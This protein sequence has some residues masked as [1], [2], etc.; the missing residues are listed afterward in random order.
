M[1]PVIKLQNLPWSANAADIRNYFDSIT[2]PHGGVQIIGGDE[3]N[4]FVVFKSEN[5]M[6]K[7]MTI[8]NGK[9]HSCPIQLFISNK[10]EMAAIIKKVR[11]VQPAFTKK[12][13]QAENTAQKQLSQKR[14]GDL[15]YS[16]GVGLSP[17]KSRTESVNSLQASPHINKY[18]GEDKPSLTGSHDILTHKSEHKD[19]EETKATLDR[20]PHH[21][22]RP[23]LNVAHN[24]REPRLQHTAMKYNIGNSDGAPKTRPYERK[25]AYNYMENQSSKTCSTNDE[26]TYNEPM[27]PATTGKSMPRHRDIKPGTADEKHFDKSLKN[28]HLYDNG[29]KLNVKQETN[30][31]QDTCLYSKKQDYDDTSRSRMHIKKDSIVGTNQRYSRYQS[32]QDTR[33]INR[34]QAFD[35]KPSSGDCK[36]NYNEIADRKNPNSRYDDW[37]DRDKMKERNWLPKREHDIDQC[38]SNTD[39]DQRPEFT[40]LTDRSDRDTK[41]KPRDI[42]KHAVRAKNEEKYRAHGK[43]EKY[44]GVHETRQ[45]D[46][47]DN[48]TCLKAERFDDSR[49]ITYTVRADRFNNNHK[50]EGISGRNKQQD[51]HQMHRTHQVSEKSCDTKFEKSSQHSLKPANS[52]SDKNRGFWTFVTNMPKYVT[53]KDVR[54]F[55]KGYLIPKDGL[56]LINSNLGKR[57]GDAFVRFRTEHMCEMALG[58]DGKTI[59]GYTVKVERCSEE[60]FEGA[61]D[62]FLPPRLTTQSTTNISSSPFTSEYAVVRNMPFSTTDDELKDFFTPIQIT[63]FI[64][65]MDVSGKRTGISYIQFA[66]E[67]DCSKACDKNRD[68]LGG[69]LIVIYPISEEKFNIEFTRCEEAALKVEDE[70]VDVCCV[71]IIG[72]PYSTDENDLHNFF[73]GLEISENGIHIIRDKHGDSTGIAYIEFASEEGCLFALK[74]DNTLLG[75]RYIYLHPMMKREMAAELP[76]A[77]ATL[78]LSTAKEN[79][80]RG[81]S[82]VT[83]SNHGDGSH[84]NQDFSRDEIEPLEGSGFIVQTSQ[85]DEIDNN[86]MIYGEIDSNSEI[87]SVDKNSSHDE[88]SLVG[89]ECDNDDNVESDQ[90]SE[91][92]YDDIPVFRVKL[93]NLHF[94]STEKDILNHFAKYNPLP[95]HAFVNKNSVGTSL[96]RGW[97]GFGNGHEAA[98]AIAS[99]NPTPLM[100]RILQLEP[101]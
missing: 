77:A 99:N 62:S 33:P 22:S 28:D 47:I 49:E 71:K 83:N 73:N 23:P 87:H 50:H 58:C 20:I 5:D 60:D 24:T 76:E 16:A 98:M 3:G 54:D 6:R 75:N 66:K 21:F 86:A 79:E 43:K 17:K 84:E 80:M 97:I 45:R 59:D 89:K 100:G 96:G 63:K 78:H 41:D 48:S 26:K 91:T 65:E 14:A 32:G 44:G 72:I 51:V 40:S 68:N 19:R 101:M 2:I 56:K 67:K 53:Y 31:E 1:S 64:L 4:A 94:D 9:I 10:T 12:S 27:Q 25:N 11:G 36:F 95:D 30:S 39:R 70:I 82:N 52:K 7:A 93:N 55:F 13:S 42:P 92:E 37:P 81:E 15:T 69:R 8:G 35:R 85:C 34:S 88:I 61:V 38:R 90:D 18:Q 46:C 29:R 74:K 57:T